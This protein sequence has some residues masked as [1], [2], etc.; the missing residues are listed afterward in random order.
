MEANVE[1]KDQLPKAE[2]SSAVNDHVEPITLFWKNLDFRVPLNKKQ[3][4]EYESAQGQHNFEVTDVNGVKMR[5]IVDNFS[6]V[7]RPNEIIGLLGPS[8][9]GKTVL[10]NIF[11]CRLNAPKGSIYNRNVYV[12]NDV[13][14]ARDLFG[15][16]AAY[17]M[18][19]DVLL[20]TL[21]PCECLSFAANLRLS[22]SQEEKDS[23]VEKIIIDL[24]LERCKNTLVGNV[25][26]KGISGGERK[27]VSIGV[28]LVT[29][30][31]L[32]ILDGIIIV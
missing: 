3:L 31:S 22:C 11:S 32:I 4:A 10:M 12:N 27:R 30:P 13:P 29:D 17:V 19:D 28:E 14:L 8:S 20:E 15:K 26:K 5:T 23:R 21:T 2:E 18:Q 24:R 6:G 7:A 25:L 16:I 1:V 9:G